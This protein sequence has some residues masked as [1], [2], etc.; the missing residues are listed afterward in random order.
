[1]GKI[2]AKVSE[3]HGLILIKLVCA[4]EMQH[5]IFYAHVHASQLYWRGMKDI[6]LDSETVCFWLVDCNYDR[7]IKTLCCL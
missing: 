6:A 2:L 7:A 3:K 5:I 1:M 4:K